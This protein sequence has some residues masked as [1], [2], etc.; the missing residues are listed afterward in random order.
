[1]PPILATPDILLIEKGVKMVMDGLKVNINDNPDHLRMTP[2]RAAHS[3]VELCEGMY[4]NP[5]KVTTFSCK[6]NELIVIKNIDFTS[7]CMHHFLIFEGTANIVYLPNKHIVGLS[8]FPRIVQ[9]IA[10]RPQVQEKLSDE[11]VD[12]IMTKIKPR[13]TMIIVKSRHMCTACR[14]VKSNL[15]FITS[16]IRGE[17]LSSPTLRTEA[18]NLLNQK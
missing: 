5:P 4:W 11:I 1:M 18:L 7:L 6:H 17:F 3:F 14:G 10:K 8:K 15:E 12:F 16:A 9:Y 2:R 13:A